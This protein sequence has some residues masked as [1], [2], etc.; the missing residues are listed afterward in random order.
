MSKTISCHIYRSK[1]KHGLYIY[2]REKDDF[3]I[4]PSALKNKLGI[5]EF[6]FSMTLEE[7]KKLVKLDTKHVMQQLQDVGYFLQMP[8]PNTN[9]L[10]LDLNQSDGF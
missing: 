8:P 5:L 1:F 6:T 7:T 4:I 10:D 9:F 2:L 3:D